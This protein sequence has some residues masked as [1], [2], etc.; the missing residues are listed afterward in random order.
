MGLDRVTEARRDVASEVLLT[1]ARL[2]ARIRRANRQNLRAMARGVAKRRSIALAGA[3]AFVAWMVAFASPR[4]GVAEAQASIT[5]QELE[6]DVWSLAAAPLEGRDSP[7]AGLERAARYIETRF[8]QAGW[9]PLGG[10]TFKRPFTRALP[11]PVPA[12]CALASTV[13]GVAKT[14]EYG[15]HFVPLTGCSGTAE[16]ELVFLGFGIES[17]SERFDE[18]EGDLRGKIALILEGEP[19]HPKRFEGPE[20]TADATLWKK[21]ETLRDNRLAGVLV[22]RR[23]PE[24]GAGAGKKK[25]EPKLEPAPLRF[26]HTWATWNGHEMTRVPEGLPSE[27]LPALEISSACAS[28]LLGEDVEA[29]ALKIDKTCQ[30]QPRKPKGRSVKMASKSRS[31][32]VSID[33]VVAALEGSD[34]RLK[35]EYVVIGAHYDH[36]GVDDR[37]RIGFGAD[38]NASGTAALLEV[39]Q[40]LSVA[41]PK[42]SVL[43]CAFAA[44]E[45]GLL[46]S[47]ALCDNLPVPRDALVAMIN[48]DMIGRGE[49]AEVAVLGLFQ[50]PGFEKVLERARKLSKTGIKNVVMRQGE[51]LFQRSDHY[52][53]HQLDVPVLFFFE[54]LPISKNADYHTWRDTIDQLDFDKIENT[55]RL[56]FN[57]T[58]LIADDEAKPPKPLASR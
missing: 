12:E 52:S 17:K 42:R 19:R 24:P 48:M 44:E 7:S 3:C 45:D 43:A 54:G 21:L 57:T 14:Y 58:W 40:A 32:S 46:G 39:M 34:E 29:L 33:N 20:V 56:V 1:T 28:E 31:G 8:E 27:L 50:N 22:V 23:A 18:V 47:K 41:R 51:D 4:G 37:G 36:I 26:R 53:F 49:T 30:P 38:D 11:E 13:D 16:G 5:R 35:H 10:E 2:L 25:G 6:V 15:A 55:T 9:K